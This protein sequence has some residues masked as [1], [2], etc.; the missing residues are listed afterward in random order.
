MQQAWVDQLIEGGVLVMPVGEGGN[1]T[2][3]RLRKHGTEM[4]REKFDACSFVPLL[5]GVNDR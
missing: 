5:T 4:V 2:L 1:Y 3:L